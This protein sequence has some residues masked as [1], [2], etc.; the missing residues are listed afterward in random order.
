MG[1]CVTTPDKPSRCDTAG[2]L[3]AND[4]RSLRPERKRNIT[5]KP[6]STVQFFGVAD[7]ACGAPRREATGAPSLE[8]TPSLLTST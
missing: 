7:D 6:Q 3:N 8:M 2:G 5:L 1:F 4:L